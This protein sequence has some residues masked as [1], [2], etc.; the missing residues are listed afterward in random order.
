[1]KSRRVAAGPSMRP[2]LAKPLLLSC[3]DLEGCVDF[4]FSGRW[5]KVEFGNVKQRSSSIAPE[6]GPL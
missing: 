3:N 6:V 2:V 4:A 5:L 1:M